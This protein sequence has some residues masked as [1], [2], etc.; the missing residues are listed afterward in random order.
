MIQAAIYCTME[1]YQNSLF[2]A[3][4]LFRTLHRTYDIRFSLHYSADTL[5]AMARADRCYD[6]YLIDLGLPEGNALLSQLRGAAPHSAFLTVNSTAF[7]PRAEGAHGAREEDG[8]ETAELSIPAANEKVFRLLEQQLDK[9]RPV[10]RRKFALDTAAG[11]NTIPF[12]EIVYVEYQDR[13]MIF[14]LES[15]EKVTSKTIRTSFGEELEL[16]LEDERFARCHSAFVINLEKA[17]CLSKKDFSTYS[18]QLVPVSKRRYSEV[19]TRFGQIR[20]KRAPITCNIEAAIRYARNYA[21]QLQYF[22]RLPVPALVLRVD[23]DQTGSPFNLVF[24]F[25]NDTFCRQKKQSRERLLGACLADVFRTSVEAMLPFCAQIAYQGTAGQLRLENPVT[26]RDVRLAG[27]QPAYGY[28]AMV[29]QPVEHRR[30]A[31]KAEA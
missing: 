19:R 30:A 18:G 6:L 25:V 5:L 15:G 3:L 22:Y 10:G 29:E 27:F 4:S 20:E 14:Y 7:L 16:L 11:L 2:D 12:Q 23:A 17:V 26:G 21:P 13:R 28:C 8:A 31:V 1:A 9:L 24:V